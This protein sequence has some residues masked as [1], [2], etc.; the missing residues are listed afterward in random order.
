[1]DV[2]GGGGGANYRVGLAKDKADWD[3]LD[4]GG[5][6]GGDFTGLSWAQSCSVDGG[7]TCL[8][9]SLKIGRTSTWGYPQVASN[10]E[11]RT[12]TRQSSTESD[13]TIPVSCR[14]QLYVPV[15]EGKPLLATLHTLHARDIDIPFH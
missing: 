15:K 3:P 13:G 7:Q 12:K 1:M 5:L 14:A 4:I 2:Q 10:C 6:P 9:S 11:D 8:I